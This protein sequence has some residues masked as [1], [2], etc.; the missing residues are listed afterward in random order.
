MTHSVISG[1]LV[2]QR[3]PRPVS[4]QVEKKKRGKRMEGRREGRSG[5]GWVD[6]GVWG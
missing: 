2:V 1:E 5:C 6:G 3:K 4:L